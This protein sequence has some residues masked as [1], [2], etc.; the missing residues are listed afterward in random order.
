MPVRTPA[1]SLD[2][3]TTFG[4][5]LKYLRRRAGLTQRELSLAVG[6][7]DAQISRLEQNQRLP[8]PATIEARFIAALFLEHE[9]QIVARLMELAADVRREDAPALGL[10]P[11]KGLLYFD[12]A[13]ADLFFG[14]EALTA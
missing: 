11:F 9:P 10:P 5:L 1:I 2:K 7:S 14:R 12:E 3:F 13:D 6:Y 4:D 8:D